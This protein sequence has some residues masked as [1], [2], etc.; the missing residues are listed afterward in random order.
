MC[1]PNC[2]AKDPDIHAGEIWCPTCDYVGRRIIEVESDGGVFISYEEMK[3][4]HRVNL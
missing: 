4:E 1:C 3:A 2:G